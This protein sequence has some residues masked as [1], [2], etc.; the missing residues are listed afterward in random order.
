MSA[1]IAQRSH[2]SVSRSELSSNWR[3][4][5]QATSD[6]VTSNPGF[7]NSRWTWP[8][9]LGR[10]DSRNAGAPQHNSPPT[11]I[12]ADE[13]AER[14]ISEGRRLYVGNLSYFAKEGDVAGLFAGE[15]FEVYCSSLVFRQHQRI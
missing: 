5:G 8:V 2:V 3:A 4:K 15:E 6:E 10:H 9:V 12:G 7:N 14:A 13:A 11:S 1:G